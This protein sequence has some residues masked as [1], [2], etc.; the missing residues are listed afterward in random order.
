M[1]ATVQCVSDGGLA[2]SAGCDSGIILLLQAVLV[3]QDASARREPAFIVHPKS[4]RVIKTARG[5]CPPTS[6]ASGIEGSLPDSFES[7]VHGRLPR[8]DHILLEGG[9]VGSYR[10]LHARSRR[11]RLSGEER[12]ASRA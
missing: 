9:L 3:R 2:E 10:R 6:T 7:A 4:L 12:C 11:G 5:T 1:Y 8:G